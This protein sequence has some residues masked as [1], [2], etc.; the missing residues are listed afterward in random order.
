M[1]IRRNRTKNEKKALN[2]IQ[3]DDKLRVHEFDNRCGFAIV[4][5]FANDTTKEKIEKQLGKV[6]KAKID[7]T[8]NS[9]TRFTKSFANL[10]KK[11][12]KQDYFELYP[13]DPITPRLYDT[14]KAHKLEKNFPMRVI[15]STVGTLPY[16][17]SKY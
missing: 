8:N 12:Y 6:T 3:R 10:V 5:V 14:I 15:V 17:I 9:Q 2:E 13:S 11:N 7:S 4:F 1:K 16:R